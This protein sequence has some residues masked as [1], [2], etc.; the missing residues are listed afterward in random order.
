MLEEYDKCKNKLD[1]IYDNIAEP[2]KVRSEISW[3]E[4]EEQEKSSNS[5]GTP[6]V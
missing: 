6:A 3:Y 4:Y 2:V 1:E 5:Y